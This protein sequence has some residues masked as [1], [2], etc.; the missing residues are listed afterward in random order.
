MGGAR[1]SAI[2]I[3]NAETIVRL[4]P[5][6]TVVRGWLH[7]GGYGG[8]VFTAHSVVAD[9]DGTLLDFTP[10]DSLVTRNRRRFI[11]H[12]GSEEDFRRIVIEQKLRAGVNG[13]LGRGSVRSSERS[14]YR[15]RHP[16]TWS[17]SVR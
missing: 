6:Y 11:R 12:P 5:R 10:A 8:A 1:E 17:P 7:A 2:A 15:A 16:P 9:R 4:D 13:L 3:A 14:Q